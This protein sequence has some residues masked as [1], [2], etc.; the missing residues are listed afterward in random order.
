MTKDNI[1]TH[2]SWL[3]NVKP[4]VPPGGRHV[5]VP[6]L[7]E[8]SSSNTA[9]SQNANISVE[10]PSRN[11]PQRDPPTSTNPRSP[12]W[13][14]ADTQSRENTRARDEPEEQDSVA[15]AEMA[16]LRA[17]P[18]SA[19]KPRLLQDDSTRP[20]QPESFAEQLRDRLASLDRQGSKTPKSKHKKAPVIQSTPSNVRQGSVAQTPSSAWDDEGLDS[21]DLTELADGAH[22]S[23]PA[24]TSARKRP[25]PG[26][27]TDVR[28][29]P[30]PRRPRLQT[31]SP[32]AVPDAG[33]FVPVE[34]YDEPPPPYST[35]AQPNPLGNES[36]L[37]PAVDDATVLNDA[38]GP[39]GEQEVRVTESPARSVP[40]KRKPLNPIGPEYLNPLGR[41]V[42]LRKPSRSPQK[43][44][45]SARQADG[46]HGKRSPTKTPS[47]KRRL[48]ADSDDEDEDVDANLGG[49]QGLQNRHQSASIVSPES[50]VRS[51]PS[52][53]TT[54]SR[55]IDKSKDFRW[56]AGP[57][58]ENASKLRHAAKKTFQT[59]KHVNRTNLNSPLPSTP[60]FQGIVPPITKADE[61]AVSRFERW[62]DEELEGLCS[63]LSTYIVELGRSQGLHMCDHGEPS[64][65]IN[66]QMKVAKGQLE[67][68]RGLKAVKPEFTRAAEKR[69]EI[70]A[71]VMDECSDG[72]ILPDDHDLVEQSRH[73]HVRLKEV[74][75][76]LVDLL[77]KAGLVEGTSVGTLPS[78]QNPKGVVVQSTQ[79]APADGFLVNRDR[80]TTNAPAHTQF[81]QQTQI[82]EK[83]NFAL[84]QSA[85]PSAP[86][87]EAEAPSDTFYEGWEDDMIT[88]DNENDDSFSVE[89]DQPTR[90]DPT[91]RNVT[92]A[93][94][95]DSDAYHRNREPR[96]QSTYATASNATVQFNEDD[97]EDDGDLYCNNMGTP[98]A[99]TLDDD[100]F[101]VDDFNDEEFMDLADD[102]ESTRQVDNEWGRES[103]EILQETSGNHKSPKK[104]AGKST[105]S[106]ASNE[107]QYPWTND[108]KA[109]LKGRFR[110]RGFRP[111]QLEAINATLSGKDCFVLMPT[112]G[113][114]SLCYQLPS[115]ITTGSTRGVT[116]V[117][118]PLL[119][120]MEDQVHHL[121]QNRIQA[122]YINGEMDQGKRKDLLDALR[123]TQV[124]RFVQVLYITPEM[125]N[126]SQVAVNALRDLNRRQRLA[127]IVIDEAHCVSQWGHDF[128][129]DYKALGEIRQQF[130]NV[131]VMALTATATENVRVDTIHNLGIQGCKVFAQ[132]FNRPNLYYEI[133]AKKKGSEVL[134][135]MAGLIKTKYRNQTG[136]IYCLSRKNCETVAE[137]LR[138]EYGI[139]AQHYHAGLSPE[140]K[141]D[142]QK[143]WQENKYKVIVATIAFGMGID[144]PDVRF[145]I[146]HSIPKSLEGYYQETG[147]AGR[148]GKRSGCYL[149]YGYQDTNL[150]KTMITKGDG[151]AQQKERQFAMLRNVVQF[152]ENKADCRRVLVLAYFGEA[153]DA[154]SCRGQCDTCNS[155]VKFETRDFTDLAAEAVRLVER[156]GSQRVTL[157]HCVD[158]F[159]G[160]NTKRIR[161]LFHDDL[162]EAGA[163]RDLERGDVERIF[164]RLVGEDALMEEHATNR[165]GFTTT[166]IKLGRAART[167]MAGQRRLELHVRA[168]SKTAKAM[169]KAAA[170]SRKKK[171]SRDV[172][173][174][175]TN[176]SSP[177]QAISGRRN[178]RSRVA[179]DEDDEEEDEDEEDAFEPMPERRRNRRGQAASKSARNQLGQPITTDQKMAQLQPLHQEIVANFVEEARKVCQ[180]IL[181]KRGLR[182]SPFTDTVLREM[183]IEFPMTEEEMGKIDGAHPEMVR[184][185]GGK[186]LQLVQKSKEFYEG[187]M[188]A[189]RDNE[190][191]PLDPNHQVV[192]VISSDDEAAGEDEEDE[193]EDD[194]D[195]DDSVPGPEMRSSYFQEDPDVAAF[196]ARLGQSQS[197]SRAAGGAK[198]GSSRAPKT[199]SSSKGSYGRKPYRRSSGGSS[200][201]RSGYKKSTTKRASGGSS[202][203]TGK[204]GGGGNGG[205]GG[206]GGIGMMPT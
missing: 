103:R 116:V 96:I 38:I 69:Q 61:D 46:G 135:D 133:R 11:A 18:S 197:T 51:S 2:I 99:Q 6:P 15:E 107:P 132:S 59:D 113:G 164:H 162:P 123:Q 53:G 150:L 12:P 176:V 70:V 91:R 136:I 50:P 194:F 157:L 158:V 141:S 28:E 163:G 73:F 4:F 105:K 23:R 115:V 120:L 140:E 185:Y 143:K 42:T 20:Q 118:S 13:N 77:R 167:Y 10:I 100:S 48:V 102:V 90:F 188:G 179:F 149:Y 75:S 180:E 44:D 80:P 199:A 155:Q 153:F 138:R 173:P 151:D 32:A 89:H 128:R 178:P 165:A 112:G 81:V 182:G 146:H 78:A 98:P 206:G 106:V 16:R 101:D 186:I 108:V 97:F 26:L 122:F 187:S 57:S 85:K 52:K 79:E 87:Y 43:P 198:G 88:F 21:I 33:D 64:A 93:N 202:W 171:A 27:E 47:T 95:D 39:L 8:P 74:K 169:A 204:R 127:R 24:F 201:A 156:I 168:S 30:T 148:D 190:G 76:K 142:T 17:A 131:P 35:V 40:K 22:F 67:A 34:A 154:A 152:C 58:S 191:V 183:A 41:S 196:N 31:S 36:L 147:R 86:D 139:A 200:K 83:M 5:A 45:Q 109:A 63:S 1:R 125:L 124:E 92:F 54:A 130:Q 144:K 159:R 3:L 71:K 181:V 84:G 7:D 9:N 121:N 160:A 66:Q 94:Q 111:H 56:H 174:L 134:D 195:L 104:L 145:V 177:I 25:S 119:S 114:K 192:L 65:A 166:Y 170:P 110:L 161:E 203:K 55:I 126:K 82:A 37:I 175:S 129:P 189:Q 184:L 19:S 172:K 14:S 68:T 49:R 72:S 60:S 117:V 205:G 193:Y 62:S 137:Q 29:G